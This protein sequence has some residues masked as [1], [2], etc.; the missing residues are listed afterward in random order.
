MGKR[1][2]GLVLFCVAVSIVFGCGP[3]RPDFLPKTF[4]TTVKVVDG[5]S[6]VEG[7]SV[8]L[9]PATTLPNVSVHGTTDGGGTAAITSLAGGNDFSGAPAGEFTVTLNKRIEGAIPNEMIV[10]PG[11]SSAVAA[12]KRE[13]LKALKEERRVVPEILEKEGTSPLKLTVAD[14][15]ELTVDLAEYK[16]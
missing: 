4:P 14:K 16:N 1:F 7:V 13:A 11:D 12:E 8:I 10:A 15:G 5:G 3:K 9:Y 2:L 6:P